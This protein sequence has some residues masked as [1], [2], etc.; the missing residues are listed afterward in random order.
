MGPRGLDM[1]RR[2]GWGRTAVERWISNW[3]RGGAG[4]HVISEDADA[5]DLNF[6]D[7]A[8]D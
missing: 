6:E 1:R 5:T 2:M 3:A 7:V 4:N 8:R